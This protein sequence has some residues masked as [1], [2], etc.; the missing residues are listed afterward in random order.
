MAG[1]ENFNN[2]LT[3]TQRL[4]NRGRRGNTAGMGRNLDVPVDSI[5]VEAMIPENK[6][7]LSS[8]KTRVEIMEYGYGLQQGFNLMYRGS[9]K[10]DEQ[11]QHPHEGVIR[12]PFLSIFGVS[13]SR[14]SIINDGKKVTITFDDGT[15]ASDPVELRP[16]GK[17]C[18]A[19]V[20][21]PLHVDEIFAWVNGRY[22][23]WFRER[24]H[25]RRERRRNRQEE[26]AAVVS[27]ATNAE[28]LRFLPPAV[29]LGVGGMGGH[30]GGR[31]TTKR[32][33]TKRKTP[34]R[35]TPK[36]KTPKRKSKARMTKQ[37]RKV[38][39]V[40]RNVRISTTGRKYVLLKGKRHFL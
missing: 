19:G 17:D 15:N 31:K 14:G 12:I 3:R 22:Q 8:G 1:G 5:C 7:W 40:T 6:G 34:K 27:E 38:K 21:R 10:K 24:H 9:H 28:A 36:R 20:T 23:L 4:V 26:E 29:P 11:V 18:P 39:G 35:K 30:N 37:K 25:T 32:K 16:T 2:L 13:G 33:T